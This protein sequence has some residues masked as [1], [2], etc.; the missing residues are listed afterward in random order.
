M[1]DVTALDLWRDRPLVDVA[2]FAGAKPGIA[3]LHEAKDKARIRLLDGG[4][5]RDHPICPPR[6]PTVRP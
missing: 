3:A 6:N 4:L 2:H 1:T 5:R